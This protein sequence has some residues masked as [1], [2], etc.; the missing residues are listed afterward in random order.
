MRFK[1]SSVGVVRI[2]SMGFIK[3]Y[4]RIHA[5]VNHIVIGSINGMSPFRCQAIVSTNDD[6]LSNGF[7][8]RKKSFAKFKTKCTGSISFL[9]MHLKMSSAKC[10]PSYIG[11]CMLIKCCPTCT[12][13][14]LTRKVIV[15]YL[16]RGLS[17]FLVDSFTA[18]L[19]SPNDRQFKKC[20]VTNKTWTH[21]V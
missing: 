17:R 4:W 2:C 12:Y 16:I 21:E 13:T 14:D 11:L 1:P 20:S 6:L 15:C 18:P 19:H 3:A 10:L 8:R 9:K 7:F 5:P